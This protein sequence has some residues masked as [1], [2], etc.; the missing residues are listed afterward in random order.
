MEGALI[1]QSIFILARTIATLRALRP[2]TWSND[3]KGK[4]RREISSKLVLVSLV[5][6]NVQRQNQITFLAECTHERSGKALK[7]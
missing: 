1:D 3:S 2:V 5:G 6:N 7:F 4:L